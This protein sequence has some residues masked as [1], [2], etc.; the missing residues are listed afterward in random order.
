MPPPKQRGMSLAKF[1]MPKNNN[2]IVE[3]IEEEKAE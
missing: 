3:E 2:M 1:N